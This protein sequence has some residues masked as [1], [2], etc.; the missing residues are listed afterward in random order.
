MR[1]DTLRTLDRW[2]GAPLC[3][4]LTLLRRLRRDPPAEETAAPSRILFVKLAEQGSTVLARPAILRAV[5]RVGRDNVFFLVFEENRFILDVLD[6]IPERN[7]I[8]IANDGAVALVRSAAAALWRL[9]RERIDTALDLEF[10]ARASAAL[11]FL[12]G[13]RWRVGFHSFHSEAAYRG[14]LMTHR[15]VYNAHLHASQVFASLVRALEAPAAS[16]PALDS[17]LE[18]DATPPRV[19]ASE[20][21]R[22]SVDR[23]LR[24]CVSGGGEAPLVLLNANCSDLLPLRRWPPER[25]VE[26]AGRLLASDPNLHIAFTGGPGEAQ[27]VEPF[28]SQVA[29]AR[30]FSLAGRTTMSELLALYERADVL[31]TNDSGPAQFATLTP[32]EV[33]VLFGPETP[34]IFGPRSPRCHVL[35]A[36]IACSPCVNAFNDRWTA[37]TDNVCM[38]RVQVDRVFETVQSIAARRTEQRQISGAGA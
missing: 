35:W 26:L 18:L 9:H 11:A 36:G 5:E 13:A 21:D 8:S 23:L 20:T 7:V 27:A 19:D 29:D 24:E 33:V 28:V 15:L 12:S 34:R 14:D 16:L 17:S 25:Y 30:C 1:V 32:I 37:C 38:Q 22:A 6:L 4:A 10:F 2:L 3:L 31:V